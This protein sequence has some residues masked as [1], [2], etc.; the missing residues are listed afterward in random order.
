[1]FDSGRPRARTRPEQHATAAKS[2]SIHAEP[3]SGRDTQMPALHVVWAERSD[4]LYSYYSGF[5]STYLH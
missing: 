4:N 1:M 5:N 3:V 2:K